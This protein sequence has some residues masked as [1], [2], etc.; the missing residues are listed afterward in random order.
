M[1]SNFDVASINYG[2]DFIVSGSVYVYV[3]FCLVYNIC[4]TGNIQWPL[5]NGKIKETKM[6]SSRMHTTRLFTVFC[7]T[8]FVFLRFAPTHP[9]CR[10]PP[11]GQTAVGLLTP[12]PQMQTPSDADP[13]DTHPLDADPQ[14]CDLWFMLGSHPRPCEQNDTP[15]L[16]LSEV[17]IKRLGLWYLTMLWCQ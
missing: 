11:C 9:G 1:P 12:P 4:I 6:H 13:L 14:S 3:V 7:S 17:K 8:P 10:P 15:K 2:G 16:H 5:R